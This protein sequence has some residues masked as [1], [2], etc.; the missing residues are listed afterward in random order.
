MDDGQRK[1]KQKLT[2]TTDMILFLGQ[3]NNK[4]THERAKEM[5]QMKM[6]NERIHRQG[7]NH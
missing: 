6:K 4:R 5:N 3:R 2:T 7:R 1:W